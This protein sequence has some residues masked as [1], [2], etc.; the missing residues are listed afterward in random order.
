MPSIKTAR[1]RIRYS[2]ERLD[3]GLNVKESPSKISPYESPDCLNVTF[4]DDGSVQT[5]K[6]SAIYNTT[7]VGS[8]PIDFGISYNDLS[9]VWAG[10]SMWHSSNTTGSTYV[11]VT[12]SSGRFASGSHVAALVYQNVLFS[13]DGTN[14]PWK[15]TGS[16]NFYNMGIDIPSA[17]TGI[18]GAAAGNIQPGT[19]YYAVSF[20]NTQ[21]VEGEMGSS[22]A[23]VTLAAT[24]NVNISEIPIGSTLAGVN[25]RFIYRAVAASG[26][27]RRIGTI[28]D[29]TTTTFTDTTV[30]GLEGAS[31]VFDGSKPTPFK[32]IA[33]LKE[34]L[35]FDDSTNRSLLRYTEF[36]NPFIS[37]ATSFEPINNGDGEDIIAVTGQDDV[38]VSFK[39][40]KSTGLI[41]N[42]PS[43]DT[44]WSK[45]EL[46]TNLGIIGP[47][48]YAPMQNA[49]IFVG[50]Q[51]NKITGLHVLTGLNVIETSDGRLRSLSISERIEPEILNNM[52]RT[53]WA[54]TFLGVFE[55]R[56]HMA[57]TKT[58]STNGSVLWLDLNRVGS[59]GQ[60][61]SWSLWS[62]INA[63]CF[64][65]H[66]GQF[67]A[68]DSTST[69]FVRSLNQDA[70]ADS[71]AAID[72]YFW[73]KSV[74]G[75]DDGTLDSYV[76]DLREIYVWRALLGNYNM[77]VSYRVDGD[78]G[79]GTSFPINL[80][81][82]SS[83]WG[84]AVFGSAFWSG[85]RDDAEVRI[86]IGRV[87]GKRFQVG[88]DNQNTINQGFRVHRAELGMNMR[89]YR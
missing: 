44:T 86:P 8:F 20:V 9:V 53:Y 27:F 68:G 74:G 26:P 70:Y 69:G 66:N 19:Y 43:D 25:E 23:G 11:K 71:G 18:S 12:Q 42:D 2:I 72:S 58:G 15:W 13:S 14:G 37:E 78:A 30:V 88:F 45:Q 10:G 67:F 40:N 31:P 64:F 54:E 1:E 6:G 5:R 55:N 73:T 84:T 48:A 52:P 35:F 76:K 24:A 4:D 36:Q 81:T 17:P 21:V 57:Y 63:K 75:E 83:L 77:N 29:N 3:G 22:S 7:L 80:A 41:L 38:V 33:L 82:G 56:L 51:N 32:T 61:G 62:G 46:P 49:I 89:R 79:S 28:S 34:R 87:Q 65:S 47:K 16:E 39:E 59:E 60:P 85:D 50:R